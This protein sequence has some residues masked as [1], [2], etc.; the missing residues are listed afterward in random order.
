M[1][2]PLTFK[3]ILEYHHNAPPNYF[4]AADGTAR[5]VAPHDVGPWEFLTHQRS[6]FTRY[7]IAP[8]IVAQKTK[9]I[10]M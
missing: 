4:T 5:M 2:T 7:A 1:P 6:F 9:N 8:T 3:D 10:I